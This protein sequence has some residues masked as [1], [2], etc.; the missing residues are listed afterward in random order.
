M[1]YG[2]GLPLV[3]LGC[4]ESESREKGNNKKPNTENQLNNI[5]KRA[6]CFL[7]EEKHCETTRLS[8]VGLNSVRDAKAGVSRGWCAIISDS[9]GKENEEQKGPVSA[10]K[11]NSRK[12]EDISGSQIHI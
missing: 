6:R 9:E 12:S 2:R 3:V 10:I 4:C 5:L 7:P 8:L 1:F 11:K